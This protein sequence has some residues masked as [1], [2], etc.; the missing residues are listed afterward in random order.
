MAQGRGPLLLDLAAGGDEGRAEQVDEEGHAVLDEEEEA[1]VVVDGPVRREAELHGDLQLRRQ[2]ALVLG[3]RKGAALVRDELERQR[4]LRRSLIADPSF[5]VLST[6]KVSSA[7]S[8]TSKASASSLNS[9]SME[10]SVSTRS[11]SGIF[12]ASSCA[13]L[14]RASSQPA[15]ALLRGVEAP[16]PIVALDRRPFKRRSTFDALPA[17]GSRNFQTIAPNLP[18]KSQKSEGVH[19]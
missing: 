4:H 10:F 15:K 3:Q 6:S 14:R 2:H 5:V 12:G 18:L 13:L 16:E 9:F 8:G 19:F 17:A 11:S 7:A 1:P